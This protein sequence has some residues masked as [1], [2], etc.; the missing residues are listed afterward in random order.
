[1]K[2]LVKDLKERLKDIFEKDKRIVAVY[3]F[4]SM[5]DGTAHSRNYG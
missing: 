2:D 5:A 4:G 1:M 3:L